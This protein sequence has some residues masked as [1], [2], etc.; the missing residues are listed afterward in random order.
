MPN[1]ELNT[2]ELMEFLGNEFTIDELKDR[3]PMIGVD[4]ERID[5]EKIIVEI[6]P[7][8]PDMLSV[9]G[10]SRA[11]KGFFGI[12]TGI[13]NYDIP[14]SGFSVAVDPKVKN[15]RP[16]I[17]CAVIK[18]INFTENSLVSLMNLQEKLHVTHGR[19]RKKVAI[20]VHDLSK[21]SSPFTYETVKFD[22]IKFVPLEFT[23]ELNLR[24]ILEKHKKGVAY[25]KLFTGVEDYPIITDKN[26]EVLSFPPI[27]NGE[28]TKVTKDTKDLFIEITGTC[29]LAVNQALNIVV[30]AAAD[31]GGEIM[32]VDVKYN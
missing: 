3:I 16:Y 6:F 24:E 29:E 14:D 4:M 25:A 15:I 32:S 21:I 28:L 26:N 8:R 20:G 10:F 23:E 31:R 1:I 30:Y 5:E 17:A 2:P 13:V 18:N 11:L 27:I 9:E 22:E 19:N 12:E 7:N